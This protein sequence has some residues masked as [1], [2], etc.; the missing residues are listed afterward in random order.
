MFVEC[1]ISPLTLL[2]ETSRPKSTYFGLGTA[3]NLITLGC[4]ANTL[5][6]E[7]VCAKPT[8]DPW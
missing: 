6:A 3:L 5:I 8:T 2:D 7:T 1:P 4:I